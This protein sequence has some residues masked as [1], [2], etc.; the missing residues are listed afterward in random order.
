MQTALKGILR[1]KT[2]DYRFWMKFVQFT[3]LI[4]KKLFAQAESIMCFLLDSIAV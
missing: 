2:K 3:V 1:I 4:C